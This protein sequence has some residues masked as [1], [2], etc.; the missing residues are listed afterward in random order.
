LVRFSDKLQG[1]EPAAADE[2]ITPSAKIPIEPTPVTDASVP[3]SSQT[4]P[5]LVLY[6][7]ACEASAIEALHP[8]QSIEENDKSE[9]RQWSLE[10]EH[11]L[12][13]GLDRFCG[14]YW[15]QLLSDEQLK[16]RTESELKDKARSLKLFFLK[17]GI[18]VPFY[19]K[20]ASKSGSS[21]AAPKKEED[22]TSAI[23]PSAEAEGL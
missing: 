21:A 15:S 5:T 9:R 6:M 7:R 18:E 8:P 23:S 1:E 22:Q 2:V 4:A 20:D 19:L 16:D 3:H 14:P 11:A 12:L 13:E 10:E 17:A